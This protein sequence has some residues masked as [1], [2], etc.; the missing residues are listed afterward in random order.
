MAP[1]WCLSWLSRLS[2]ACCSEYCRRGEHRVHNALVV[3]Q[4]AIGLVLLVSSGLLIRSFVRILNVDPGF[5]P[6]HVLTARI[7]VSFDRLNRDQRF[8]FYQQLVARLSD[9][10]GVQSASAGWPLPMSDSIVHISFNIQGRPIAR[11][12]E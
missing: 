2:R 9:L 8:Q 12:D 1:Y 10:G 7:R 4:T 5:D 6:K 3:A 11:E